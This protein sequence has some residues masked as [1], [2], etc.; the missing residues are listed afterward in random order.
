MVLRLP[1]KLIPRF[2]SHV[3]SLVGPQSFIPKLFHGKTILMLFSLEVFMLCIRMYK[4]EIYL[5]N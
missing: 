5:N 1:L 2:F 3:M 4:H